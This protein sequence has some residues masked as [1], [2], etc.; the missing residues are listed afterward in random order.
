MKHTNVIKITS[1][2]CSPLLVCHDVGDLKKHNYGS[3]VSDLD[4]YHTIQ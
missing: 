4:M 1:L 3:H 2:T